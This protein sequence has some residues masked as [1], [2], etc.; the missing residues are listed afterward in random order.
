MGQ[1]R[2]PKRDHKQPHERRSSTTDYVS[3]EYRA[4]SSHVEQT[5]FLHSAKAE[6]DKRYQNNGD[7]GDRSPYRKLSS[8]SKRTRRSRSLRKRSGTSGSAP[9]VGVRSPGTRTWW[10]P[11]TACVEGS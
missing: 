2:K 4:R 1:T 8:Y 11:T 5:K 3:S 9:V 6:S 7:N 10:N